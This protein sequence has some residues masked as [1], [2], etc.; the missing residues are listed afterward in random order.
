MILNIVYIASQHDAVDSLKL[1]LDAKAD[2]E[3][4]TA[5]GFTSIYIAASKGCLQSMT[6]L[7]SAK[8]RCDI[9]ATG[10]FTAVLNVA[11]VYKYF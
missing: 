3:A 1:L 7:L 11:L 9:K 10:G 6:L 8:A 2:P 4:E 5:K